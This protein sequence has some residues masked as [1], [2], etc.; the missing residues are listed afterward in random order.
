M[1]RYTVPESVGYFGYMVTQKKMKCC[2]LYV[3]VCTKFDK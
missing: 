3:I 2:Q 1:Q